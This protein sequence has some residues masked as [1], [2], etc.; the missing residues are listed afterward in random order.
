MSPTRTSPWKRSV[1]AA[2]AAAVA[3]V[4]LAAAVPAVAADAPE[5]FTLTDPDI[6]ESSGLAAS[7]QHSGV[8]WTHNDSSGSGDTGEPSRL[9]AIDGSTGETLA[10]ITLSG[11]EGRDIEAV[12]LGPD[13]DLYVGDIGDNYDGAWSE[14]WIYRLPEPE[15][16]ADA[17]VTP[18]VYTA[19]YEDGARDAEALMVHPDT[20]RVYLVSKKEDGGAALYAGPTGGLSETGVTTFTRVAGIDLWVTDGAFSPDGTRLLLRSYFGSQMYR[21]QDGRPVAID[22]HV[23]TPVQQQGESVTFT[24]DGRYLMFGTEGEDSEVEPV[25]LTGDL[26]PAS[27]RQAD[28]E[29]DDANGS[30][31][32]GGDTGDGLSARTVALLAVVLAAVLLTR[33]RRTRR[34]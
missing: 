7:R 28:A 16:L 8:Y 23:S 22:E 21:W 1:T 20:G 4:V 34:A 27:A 9:Y 24:T 25:E 13:G 19:R 3:A 33:W 30:A 6:T 2:L 11:V 10:T 26:L 31:G 12:S 18:T 5:A 29:E 14:V 32:A 15:R 17:T